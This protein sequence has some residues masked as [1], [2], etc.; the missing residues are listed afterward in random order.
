MAKKKNHYYVLVLTNEGPTFVT[1]VRPNKYAEFNKLEAPKEFDKYYAEDMALGLNLNLITAF[2][3]CMP[4]ELDSQPYLY[5]KG[6]FE[7]K[8]NSEEEK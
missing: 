6:H 7:W 3:V 1:G 4:F 5:N 2:P 8:Y